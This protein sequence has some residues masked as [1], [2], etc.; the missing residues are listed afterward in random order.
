MNQVSIP[1]VMMASVVFYVGLYYVRMYFKRRETA[2]ILFS[3]CCFII[4][5]YDVFCVGLYNAENI[6][7]GVAWQRLQL[8]TLGL[9]SISICWFVYHYTGSRLKKTFFLLTSVFVTI[10]FLG[11]LVEGPLTLTPDLPMIKHVRI[12][13]VIDITYY[14][15]D[16][17]AIYVAQFVSILACFMFMMYLMIGNYRSGNRRIL[18]VVIAF[19]LFFFAAFN[20]IMVSASVYHFVYLVEYAYMLIIL[21]MDQAFLNSFVDLHNKFRD[22]NVNL[23][24][25]VASRTEE[26]KAAFEELEA[27]NEQLSETNASL[28]NAY[29]I[30]QRDMNMAVNVQMN[31][32]PGEPP[33]MEGWDIAFS[34]RPM[35]GV[36]GDIY[37]F[38]TFNGSLLGLS[39]FDVSGHGISSGL[40]TLLAKSIAFRNFEKDP[41]SGLDLVM[42]RINRELIRELG[43][44]DHYLTG[45]ILRFQEN[46]VQYVNAAH[47]DMLRLRS[48]ADAPE[49]VFPPSGMM[50]GPILGVEN[51]D[52]HFDMVEFGM[53]TGDFLLLYTDALFESRNASG[54]EF[55][56]ERVMESF[57]KAAGGSA[58][59]TL[60]RIIDDFSEFLGNEPISD[61]MTV[62][63]IKRTV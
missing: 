7:E 9:L 51:D 15:A 58:R 40:I 37:D 14:E 46:N 12:G 13:S 17:G 61:D 52:A 21:S 39:L 16:P 23:E 35:A 20:D 4:A 11:L 38:Y 26:L 53:G 6:L 34:Y 45:I 27:I 59:E 22:L 57:R 60:S 55:G 30:A 19:V 42:A 5:L 54:E 3:L 29:R 8:A 1:V 44:V 50:K 56:F 31:I 24:R 25:K 62:L 28:E 47:P 32:L 49:P 63:T 41:G 33:A 36:S 10:F 2:S 48:G 18:P 43:A